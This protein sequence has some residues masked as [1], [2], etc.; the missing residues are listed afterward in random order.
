M[1]A[2]RGNHSHP[3]QDPK[4]QLWRSLCL[5]IAK[6]L[7]LKDHIHESHVCPTCIKE[8]LSDLPNLCNPQPRNL[9]PVALQNAE[10][11]EAAESVQRTV[12]C[13]GGC[14]VQTIPNLIE[15]VERFELC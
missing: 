14:E 10:H 11:H 9:E 6:A 5:R 4:P 2:S 12:E 1:R 7:Y 15:L 8:T 13:L 3:S